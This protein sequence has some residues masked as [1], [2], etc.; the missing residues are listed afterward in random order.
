MEP[1]VSAMID[2]LDAYQNELYPAE[3]N[4]L[5]S[6]ETLSEPTCKFLGAFREGELVGIGSAKMFSEFGELKRFFVP[7]NMRGQGV[8]ELMI[9]SLEFWLHQNGIHRS[10]LETGIHQHAAIRFYQKLGYSQVGPFG[11]YRPDPLSVFMEKNKNN[12]EVTSS[13]IPTQAFT[14]VAFSSEL[15][16]PSTK[17]HTLAEEMVRLA[18]DQPGLIGFH[19][20]RSEGGEGFTASYWKDSES[21]HKW[22]ANTRHQ[23]VQKLG[24]EEFYKSYRI[25]SAEVRLESGR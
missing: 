9:A 18:K 2:E 14:L 12:F 13:I 17:Y 25:S 8:A 20:F 10:L 19:S 16:K 5:D 22:G 24:R 11:N 7:H 3:S 15:A 21:M 1:A 4:H 6:R 23:E